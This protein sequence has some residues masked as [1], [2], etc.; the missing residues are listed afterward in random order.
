MFG[1]NADSRLTLKAF[2]GAVHPDDRGVV[3]AA[4]RAAAAARETAE[5]RI[6]RRSS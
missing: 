6:P 4:M 1:F 3:I 5:K 2:L